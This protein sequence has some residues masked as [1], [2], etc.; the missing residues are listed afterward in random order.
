MKASCEWLRSY[1]PDLDAGPPEMVRLFTFSGTEVEEIQQTGDDCVL[2]LGVTSNR[3]DCLGHVGLAR[4]LAALTGSPLQVPAP[5]PAEEGGSAEQA[6]SVE[7]ADPS[8][9][10][11][12]TARIVEGL[13]VGPSPDWLRRRLEAVGVTPVNNV[14]DVTNFVLLEWNQPLHAFDLDR[15]QGR[16]IIV[17]RA[18]A[19]EELEAINGRTYVLDPADL[20]I[21]DSGRPVALAGVMGGRDTEVGPGT[22]R[23]LLESA[24]FEPVGVRSTSRRH[25]LS[26]DSS[27]RFERGLDACGVLPASAR[28]AELLLAVCGGRLGQGVLSRGGPGAPPGPV[29]FR[30][31][32]FSRVCGLELALE[33]MAGVLRRLGCLVKVLDGDGLEVVPPPFRRDLTREIDLVEEVIR[34]HGL[35]HLPGGTSMKV[36]APSGSPEWGFK[37]R[38][39]DRLAVLG[40]Q[41]VMTPDF[42]GEDLPAGVAF[43]MEGGVLRARHPVRAG[44]GALRRSLLP[45]LLQV[46]KANADA[47]NEDLRLFEVSELHARSAGGAL[48]RRTAAVGL[49]LDGDLR[50]ARGA[51]EALLE[52]LGL[53]LDVQPLETPHLEQAGSARL[54]VREHVTGVLGRPSRELVKASGLKLRPCFAE[55]DLGVLRVMASGGRT[56]QELPRYPAVVRDL[57]L[58]VDERVAFAKLAATAREALDPGLLESLDL[59]GEIYRGRPVPPGHRNL[60]LRL[61]FRA[62]DR[63]LR[64]EEVDGWVQG[65][66]EALQRQHRAELR[67]ADP[68]A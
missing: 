61:V 10:P 52:E 17:R 66:V 54:V 37:A 24:C 20:V 68:R 43:L 51:V 15:L 62:S 27:F 11:Y 49:L 50:E 32:R 41:E 57:S 14:V 8:G 5:D 19:G 38:V 67:G 65:A 35:D 12:Y 9:C 18:R 60:V 59:H 31:E 6:A 22:T 64:S 30:R 53:E 16:S 46:R 42:V 2:D 29:L 33:E 45:S 3:V 25:R 21:A 63:T 4:E 1:V 47:G 36:R 44:E 13:Q 23:V 40:L 28:A 48:P 34:V 58:V 26:T 7:V 56:F 39:K 55:L